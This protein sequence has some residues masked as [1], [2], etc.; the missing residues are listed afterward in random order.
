MLLQLL[1]ATTATATTHGAEHGVGTHLPAARAAVSAADLQLPEPELKKCVS[2]SWL[3]S[4][5]E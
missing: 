5:D 3:A 2:A 4:P 1:L